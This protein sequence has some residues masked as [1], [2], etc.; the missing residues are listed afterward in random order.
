MSNAVEKLIDVYR[1]APSVENLRK[2]LNYDI[3]CD[4]ILI[5]WMVSKQY[6]FIAYIYD[7]GIEKQIPDTGWYINS[8]P[9]EL[10]IPI[11]HSRLGNICS[12][13]SSLGKIIYANIKSKKEAVSP[14]KSPIPDTFTLDPVYR[15]IA[16]AFLDKIAYDDTLK[17]QKSMQESMLSNISHSIR[18]PLNGILHMCNSIRESTAIPNPTQECSKITEQLE[19]LNQSAVTLATNIFDIVDLTKLELGKLSLN[20]EV[21]NVCELIN[22]VMS[23][24]NSL[25]RN[26]NVTLNYYISPS[27]PDYIYSDRKRIKQILINIIENSLSYTSVG[28]VSLLVDSTVINLSDEDSERG[29]SIVE[30]SH[31][32]YGA[33][34][35]HSISFIIKDTGTGMDDPVKSSLFKPSEITTSKQ[36]GISLKISSMLSTLLNGKISLVYSEPG[37]GSCF[38]FSLVACEEEMPEKQTNTLKALKG[39]SV[40]LIDSTQERIELC[41]ILEKYGM[42]YTISST[43]DEALILHSTKKFDMIM[44]HDDISLETYK[45][46][47]NHI[48]ADILL[49]I[50]EPLKPGKLGM[51]TDIMPVPTN[52]EQY[53]SKILELFN[54][55]STRHNTFDDCKILVVEDEQINRIVIEKILRQLGYKKIYLAINGNDALRQFD[56]V[57]PNVMLIDIRMPLMNGFELAENIHKTCIVRGLDEPKMIGVT[58]QVISEEELKPWFKEFVYKP[59]D[60]FEL[61]KKIQEL[62]VTDITKSV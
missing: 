58:A 59:I 27:V 23:V 18:T 54:D 7:S 9:D 11:K 25:N 6:W 60:I 37:K 38:E 41:K 13:K 61:D 17:R 33:D 10:N 57:R 14:S 53:K 42:L 22:T 29:N 19:Y 2:I 50:G 3:D 31:G 26:K 30:N 43:Y 16:E 24:A 52:P 21:F 20:K 8:E 4:F 47:K 48:S 39:K 34:I 36:C 12:I 51:F 46:I 28:E 5:S 32:M 15:F 35:Q 45:D 1:N 40:L 62:L 56:F 49:G 55:R 44:I